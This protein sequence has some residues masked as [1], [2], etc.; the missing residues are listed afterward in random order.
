AGGRTRRH[1]RY[2]PVA[3]I[4]IMIA[5]AVAPR[6]GVIAR[7]AAQLLHLSGRHIT[8]APAGFLALAPSRR[9]SAI[10]T[11][12]IA[13]AVVVAVMVAVAFGMLALIVDIV[14][15]NFCVAS[16]VR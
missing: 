4:A 16:A 9:T 11:V 12:V 13:I 3:V 8:V 2:R 7:M 15:G 10:V 1:R 5:I 14:I 6:Y